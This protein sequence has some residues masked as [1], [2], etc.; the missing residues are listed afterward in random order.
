MHELAIKASVAAAATIAAAAL[1]APGPA[2]GRPAATTSKKA[3]SGNLCGLSIAGELATVNI[4]APCVKDK[5]TNKTVK[6][7]LGTVM[8]QAFLA[9]WGSV[10]RAGVAHFLTIVV[11]RLTGSPSALAYGRTKL[12][13]RIFSRGALVSVGTLA[14]LYT[15]TVSCVNPPKEDC[16]QASVLAYVKT[17][18]L[19]SSS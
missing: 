15:E 19:K 12:R 13:G 7:P 18:S 4:N 14:S 8:Q 1:I 16:T 10:P 17:T 6:T 3:F 11:G 5:T 9:H 2:L